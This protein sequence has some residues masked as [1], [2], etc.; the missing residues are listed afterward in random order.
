M[1]SGNPRRYVK[2]ATLEESINKENLESIMETYL[3]AV[4]LY[5]NVHVSVTSQAGGI[6]KWKA[7]GDELRLFLSLRET[8]K[9]NGALKAE[10]LQNFSND[11]NAFFDTIV[12]A[13]QELKSKRE[14][15]NAMLQYYKNIERVIQA[16]T[17]VLGT[18]GQTQR[19]NVLS[20]NMQKASQMKSK[21]FEMLSNLDTI[22]QKVRDDGLRSELLGLREEIQTSIDKLTN[23]LPSTTYGS[24]TPRSREE[25]KSVEQQINDFTNTLKIYLSS[26]KS[27]FQ[28]K[29]NGTPLDGTLSTGL[30][31]TTTNIQSAGA[32]SGLFSR[33]GTMLARGAVV[34]PSTIKAIGGSIS[35]SSPAEM[36]PELYLLWE[37]FISDDNL[38]LSPGTSRVFKDLHDHKNIMF[39]SR[40][41][42]DNNALISP[43]QSFKEIS[44]LFNKRFDYIRKKDPKYSQRYRKAMGIAG[45][46]AVPLAAAAATPP[47]PTSPSPGRSSPS[48][49]KPGK[50]GLSTPSPSPSASASP[51][52]ILPSF[53]SGSDPG[54]EI[55]SVINE[56]VNKISTQGLEDMPL[57]DTND[58]YVNEMLQNLSKLRNKLATVFHKYVDFLEENRIPRQLRAD[59]S[60]ANSVNSGSGGGTVDNLAWADRA[61]KAATDMKGG[62]GEVGRYES[63]VNK[64]KKEATSLAPDF[65][66]RKFDPLA[67]RQYSEQAE[68]FLLQILSV[69]RDQIEEN[70]DDIK[71]FAKNIGKTRVQSLIKRAAKS[72]FDANKKIEDYQKKPEKFIVGIGEKYL[73]EKA[74]DTAI[75]TAEGAATASGPIGTGSG[76][77]EA[78]SEVNKKM[79]EGEN[80]YE[81]GY[82]KIHQDDDL[83]HQLEEIQDDS[84]YLEKRVRDS[85]FDDLKSISTSYEKLLLDYKKKHSDFLW[86]QHRDGFKYMRYWRTIQSISEGERK[87]IEE[88]FE[89]LKKIRDVSNKTL[90]S[91]RQSMNKYFRDIDQDNVEE[92]EDPQNTPPSGGPNQKGKDDG[93][94]KKDEEK[95]DF[96]MEDVKQWSRYLSRD[97]TE[98][99]LDKISDS[100]MS[101]EDVRQRIS[102]MY[103]GKNKTFAEI[104]TSPQLIITFVF[105]LVRLL[106]LYLAL[107][108]SERNF[109]T[110]YAKK[111]YGRNQDPPHPF[112]LVIVA[113]AVEFALNLLLFVIL[114][115]IRFMF[116]TRFSY[117]QRKPGFELDDNFFLGYITDYIATTLILLLIAGIISNIIKKKKYFRYRYEGERGIRALSSMMMSIAIFIYL[118]PF[119]RVV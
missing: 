83:S 12:N 74:S 7:G 56:I 109:L 75:R 18:S 81:I 1:T 84:R 3:K 111:V 86:D 106:F 77:I 104:A 17:A 103:Y 88:Y 65:M 41:N 69:S 36:T 6:I 79:L 43:L 39:F 23:L 92:E 114:I 61:I 49:F 27:H 89:K 78:S 117:S 32:S 101:T 87:Y 19:G 13:F 108:Y 44:R 25:N 22:L 67:A 73:T 38:K 115:I 30:N 29:L 118:I 107:D 66:Y 16:L 45:G 112:N 85:L 52:G 110:K 57:T 113:L 50:N 68:M 80:K 105:K 59:P 28:S 35:S 119:S 40:D 9:H 11:M 14:G 46:N 60:S 8:L 64:V 97:Q 93:D 58:R 37:D 31:A 71:S 51:M 116:G 90:M 4:H 42:Y 102:D 76:G 47:L 72:V 55:S 63:S 98:E 20:N 100:I 94:K 2:S 54:D 15:L 91:M 62:D 82:A 5:S 21:C 26:Q 33:P 34:P 99:I 95:R 10:W 70:Q 24:L 53:K 96:K 48:L